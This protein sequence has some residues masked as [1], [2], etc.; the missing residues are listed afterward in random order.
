MGRIAELKLSRH[1]LL[2][3]DWVEKAAGG[4]GVELFVRRA[5]ELEL[6]RH[7]LLEPDLVEKATGGGEHQCTWWRRCSKSILVAELGE[8]CSCVRVSGG[9]DDAT[10]GVHI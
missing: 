6:S 3:L 9:G 10:V 2:E 5:A 4:G 7:Y 1:Y 8:M